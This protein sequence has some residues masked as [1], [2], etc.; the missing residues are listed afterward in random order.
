M[1]DADPTW[2]I[3]NAVENV[4]ELEKKDEHAYKKRATIMKRFRAWE[5]L[6]KERGKRITKEQKKQ[7]LAYD[8]NARL[9]D[10]QIA[11]ILIEHVIEEMLAEQRERIKLKKR[12]KEFIIF[13]KKVRESE[14]TLISI[15]EAQKREIWSVSKPL[16]EFKQAVERV[17][18]TNPD[19]NLRRLNRII[20]KQQ[21]LS[22][23]FQK[24]INYQIAIIKK[25]EAYTKVA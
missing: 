5:T 16:A 15:L 1:V 18:A 9:L 21:E 19:H 14:E 7:I 17:L 24:E 2:T 4:E 20:E 23:K 10:K 3:K 22:E 6:R 25:E 12:L 13:H 11:R 8:P